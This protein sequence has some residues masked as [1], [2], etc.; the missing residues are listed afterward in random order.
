[1]SL[2]ALAE[3]ADRC[4]AM[5]ARKA[6]TVAST[7][8]QNEDDCEESP[9]SVSAVYSG[10]SSQCGGKKTGFWQ[11]KKQQYE[12]QSKSNSPVDVA[13]VAS[14]LC[15]LCFKFGAKACSWIGK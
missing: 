3:K 6:S 13:C 7:V 12:K 9:S 10:G 2:C 11:Q 14:G 8:L 15:Y 4:S 5:L 1:M